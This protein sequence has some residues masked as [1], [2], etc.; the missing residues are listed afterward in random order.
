MVI[1]LATG[2][3]ARGFKPGRERRNFKGDRNP[4]HNFLRREVKPS[5]PCRKILRHAEDPLKYGET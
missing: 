1:V 3:N 2:H 5:A 4:Q